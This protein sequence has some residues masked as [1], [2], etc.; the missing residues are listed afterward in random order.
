[1]AGTRDLNVFLLASH[2]NMM[3]PLV[4]VSPTR[5]IFQRNH[6]QLRK[7]CLQWPNK[8]SKIASELPA[9]ERYWHDEALSVQST[10]SARGKKYV[11][12]MFPYPSGRLHM[13]HMRVYSIS[14][15]L[16]RYY[17]LNDYSVIH[18]IGWD[19][20]G[21]P[22]ENAARERNVEPK[23]WTQGNIEVMRK[24]LLRSG[25]I[26]DWERE[27]CT[28]SPDYYRWTQWLFCRLH[29]H[30]LAEHRHAEVNW[31]PV[32]NTVLAEEQIDI[33]GLSWRSG[34][35]AE[36]RKLKQ[37]HIMT[38]K[39]A[40]RLSDGLKRLD[41]W[42]DIAD[43]Q[44]NWIGPCDVWRFMLQMKKKNGEVSEEF[45]DLRIRDPSELSQCAMLVIRKGH[46]LAGGLG[47]DANTVVLN[48]VTG[49]EMSIVFVPVDETS[50]EY[51][52][53]ARL[54]HKSSSFDAVLAKKFNVSLNIAS[55]RLDAEDVIQIAQKGKYGGYETSENL[56]DWVVSRQ[57]KWG[58]PIPVLFDAVNSKE[59]VP[60]LDQDL[61]VLPQ[62]TS[63]RELVPC[64]RLSSG[65]GV[66][67]TDTLDT[68]FD[69][70]WYYLR[71][72]DSHNDRELISKESCKQ[73]PVDVYVGGVEHAAV[74]MFFARF[75]SYFLHDIGVM[76]NPEPFDHLL[77]QGVVRAKTF[78]RVDNGEYL[79]E[80]DIIKK[81][82]E[83][84]DRKD[85]YAVQVLYDKMSKSKHNGVDP[86]QLLDSDGIDL[87]RLQLIA[88]ASPRSH[89]DWGATDNRGLKKWLNRVSSLVNEYVKQRQ[90]PVALEPTSCCETE[91][92]LR[93]LY[94]AATRHVIVPHIANELWSA[95]CSVPAINESL[96]NRNSVVSEQKWPIPDSDAETEFMLT[97]LRLSCGRCS[98]PR[99]VI[100]NCSAEEALKLSKEKYH[101]LFFD[102]LAESGHEPVTCKAK[103]H[104]GLLYILTLKFDNSVSEKDLSKILKTVIRDVMKVHFI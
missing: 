66:R 39:F 70:S 11:L 57:R 80:A 68:F 50:S 48:F 84:V 6:S 104:K 100:E 102:L 26:F 54:A 33:N 42:E 96:W 74:H 17:R 63:N 29:S 78:I 97:A 89:I 55:P 103:V 95:L 101:R 88:A 44:S 10:K 9:I 35:R 31:D 47:H 7:P 13:G 36:K 49:R 67:E 93:A 32:D 28:C 30:G 81:G 73:M 91:E 69:S 27:L 19:A 20:F 8:I 87:T 94:N 64:E 38:T 5:I 85:G 60:V 23:E 79:K 82:S 37:W 51:F 4:V 65:K 24:Q 56:L 43:I 18:P 12:S 90:V 77:T 34:A 98:V 53:N 99:S 14:D 1:M 75:M 46:P 86:L 2:W 92:E 25:I 40:K 76:E 3:L 41:Q 83:Y 16:A 58:T 71:F 15:V 45:F 62:H 72:L 59:S 22:A 21:L 61:P 52:L